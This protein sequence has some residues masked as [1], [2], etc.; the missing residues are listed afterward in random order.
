M[1]RILAALGII[2]ASR[3]KTPHD[4]R[5]QSP[6]ARSGNGSAGH[7]RGSHFTE[8]VEAVK[9]LK[10]ERRHEEAI[11]LLLELVDATEA[12]ANA[13]GFGAAPWYYVQLAIIYRKERRFDDEVAILERAQDS[14]GPDQAMATRLQKA[15]VLAA[16]VKRP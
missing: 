14:V 10:R 16:G 11:A 15:R 13:K 9:Q 5:S 8:Y 6:M 3:T 2:S 7:V 12:E 1:R 4:N